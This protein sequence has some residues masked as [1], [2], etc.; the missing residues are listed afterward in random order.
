MDTI[1]RHKGKIII[2]AILIGLMILGN[3]DMVQDDKAKKEGYFTLIGE[4]KNGTVEGEIMGCW[5]TGSASFVV[6]KR[7]EATLNI[8]AECIGGSGEVWDKTNKGE[9][10]DGFFVTGETKWRIIDRETGF[11]LV[12]VKE[13]VN[14]DII[15]QK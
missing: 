7:G 8:K 15:F 3:S 9:I 12:Q 11:K 6:K 10:E 1:K 2:A 4:H 5:Y 14:L 13:G